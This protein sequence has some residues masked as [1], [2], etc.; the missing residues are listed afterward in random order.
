MFGLTIGS[1]NVYF[2]PENENSSKL[3]FSMSGDQGDEW[4]NAVFRL[5]V[6]E[7]NFQV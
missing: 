2:K 5:P 3:M 4:R 6:V 1:L 7:T